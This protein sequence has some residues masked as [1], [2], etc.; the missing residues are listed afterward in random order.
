MKFGFIISK[1]EGNLNSYLVKNP[2]FQNE[3]HLEQDNNVDQLEQ[4]SVIPGFQEE[5]V[6]FAKKKL[7]DSIEVQQFL[8]E[9]DIEFQEKLVILYFFFLNKKI[10]INYNCYVYR[11]I[12][13]LIDE[14]S[15][16]QD[17]ES[18]SKEI[19]LELKS[20]KNKYEGLRKKI[21]SFK[22]RQQKAVG[23]LNSGL[24]EI[25]ILTSPNDKFCYK[26]KNASW[27]CSVD[28]SID[29][30]KIKLICEKLIGLEKKMEVTFWTSEI[31]KLLENLDQRHYA[32][33][34]GIIIGMVGC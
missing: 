6:E 24:E 28:N 10:V 13:S 8:V 33:A 7:L 2:F 34:F 1:P 18:N 22:G 23:F 20:S 11:N 3:Y 30:Q 17:D 16:N 4:F 14:L 27:R 19:H 15:D 29:L 26:V 32:V 12:A 5:L 21:A 9:R 25:R 31:M